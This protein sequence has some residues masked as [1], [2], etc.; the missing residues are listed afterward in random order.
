MDPQANLSRSS[1]ILHHLTSFPGGRLGPAAY[2]FVDWLAAAGQSWWQILPLGPPDRHGS[3]YT[4]DS[5]FA[6]SPA[7][8]ADTAAPVARDE[9]AAFR[10]RNAFWI[11]GW[12]R[13]AGGAAVADQVRFER[14][15]NALRAHAANRGVRVIGDLPIY[16]APDRADQR[17]DP[18]L[19]MRGVVA[20]APPDAL[21]ADGQLW[22]NPLYEWPALE[23]RGYRWWTERF[24]RTF[25]LCDLARIDHFR[26]FVSFWEVAEGA[27]SARSGRWHRG[28]GAAVF[29]ASEK[30]LGPLPLIAEDLGVITPGVRRLR[31]ALG[32]PGML[33]M[34]FAFEGSSSN[35]HRLENHGEEFVVYTGTHDM[36]TA[37]GWW[38]SLS[39]ARRST[40]GLDPAE[41]HWSLIRGAYGSRAKLAIVPIQDVLGLGSEARMN[42]PG[43]TEGNWSWR[44]EPG[45]LT[46]ELAAR[47]RA[48]T[49]AAGRI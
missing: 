2:E 26:G 44:L 29:R 38:R 24:R 28:P 4:A 9:E 1:G 42:V 5:V 14:E 17:S 36:D 45:Q 25:E 37:V 33:V 35:P 3:P 22:G 15:W 20:G 46:R 23:R 12:E 21:N 49:V 34:Q 7:L 16:V 8:L 30:A 6:A 40:T 13:F 41:P 10:L 31:E 18:G 47:L 48:E 43:T 27:E 11:D 32:Y 19:F 39:E